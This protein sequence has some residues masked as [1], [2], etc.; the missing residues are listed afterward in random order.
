MSELPCAVPNPFIQGSL[1]ACSPTA[2]S[3]DSSYTVSPI[4]T[5]EYYLLCDVVEAYFILGWCTYRHIRKDLGQHVEQN[6]YHER[7]LFPSDAN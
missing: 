1:K 3:R 7:R 4:V 5:G 2:G 6:P